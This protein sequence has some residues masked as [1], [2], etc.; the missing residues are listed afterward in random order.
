M[1]KRIWKLSASF[2]AA[3]KACAYR[4][5]AQYVLGIRVTEEAE[6]LRVGTNWHEVLEV[7]GG[8]NS[9]VCPAC[10]AGGPDEGC[11]I[12]GGDMLPFEDKR[13]GLRLLL[14][15]VY[16]D[17]PASKSTED[18]AIEKMKLWISGVGYDWYYKEDDF[19]IL[20][21]EVPF[22]I[23]LFDADGEPIEGVTLVGKI[24]KITRS[25]QGTIFIDEHK[26]TS[27]PIDS[28]SKFWSHLNLDTQTTLYV[29][30]AQTL[31]LWGEL[32]KYG[33]KADDPLI[34]GI[35]Y[36]V[37]KKPQIKA[38]DITMAEAK[39]FA[40]TATYAEESFHILGTFGPSGKKSVTI[41]GEPAV[42]SMD[43]G[44]KK[45]KLKLRET[46]HMY[47]ARLMHSIIDDPQKYF[48][49]RCIAR[50]DAD[51]ERFEK[52]LHGIFQTVKHMEENDLWYHN[53]HQCEAT[54][55][56]PYIGQCYNNVELDPDNPP[57][58][59]RCIF[60]KQKEEISNATE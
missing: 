6:T 29:Y 23:P 24:D 41:N 54:F 51:I 10:S 27:K 34:R 22:N 4:C 14:N 11:Y 50:T 32:E 8:M 21:E 36:D 48:A 39:V 57:E 45:D 47:G 38:K 59:F 18:W 42:Y 60:K 40:E 33:I 53:E 16:E 9:E 46:S 55:T 7:L 20:A 44:P 43:G 19:E 5:Y 28:D 15:D 37:W 52:E 25:P 3:F 12:C 1:N 26:S 58:G 13:E 30:A 17:K 56:C 31:Q 35:R 49:R 2:I